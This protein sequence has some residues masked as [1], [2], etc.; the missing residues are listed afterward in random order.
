MEENEKLF[1]AVASIGVISN[2]LLELANLI[3]TVILGLKQEETE[4]QVIDCLE[5]I[6]MCVKAIR[7]MTED[8]LME[9]FNRVDIGK[10]IKHE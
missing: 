7:N 6:S 2:H 8:E 5:C 1:Q 3:D 4:V 9:N 10:L